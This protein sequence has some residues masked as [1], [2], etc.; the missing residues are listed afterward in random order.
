MIPTAATA[1]DAGTIARTISTI[2][3]DA[4]AATTTARRRP[5]PTALA[6]VGLV[7]GVLS[8]CTWCVTGV[9]AVIL[10]AIALRKPTG[11]GMAMAGLILGIIGTC[12][13]VLGFAL[14]LPAVQKVREAAARV[15]DTHNLK[16]ISF[17][18]TNYNDNKGTLPPAD[19]SLSWRV[20]ILP[21]MEQNHL[22]QKFNRNEPWD[23]PNNRPLANTVIPQYTS[24]LDP[25]QPDTRYRVFVGPGT[26]YPPGRAPLRLADIN[27]GLTNTIFAIEA[28]DAVPWPQPKELRY[29]PN[30]PLP[31]LGAPGRNGVLAVFADGSVRF[32]KNPSEQNLRKMI[33][34]EGGEIVD[35]NKP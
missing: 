9:P 34:P 14:L 28:A 1:S 4:A 24:T 10:S 19:A 23:G 35:P 29:D 21:F 31:Q 2:A 32:M 26:L 30:G 5:R 11:R 20:E 8:L 15:K 17:A 7:L 12:L 27:D 6:V 25:N 22:Y 18:A 13:T 16:T 3:R 33:T